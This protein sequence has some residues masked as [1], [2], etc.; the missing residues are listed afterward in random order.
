MKQINYIISHRITHK[1]GNVGQ[2]AVRN[3]SCDN[4]DVIDSLFDIDKEDGNYN[5]SRRRSRHCRR[6]NIG[7]SVI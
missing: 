4:I 6:L 7:K 5:S 3:T 1:T 2:R